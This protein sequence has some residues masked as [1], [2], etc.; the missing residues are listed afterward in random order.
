MI[1]DWVEG[2][3]LICDERRDPVSVSWAQVVLAEGIGSLMEIGTRYV[4]DCEGDVPLRAHLPYISDA[5]LKEG[6]LAPASL[7]D[8]ESSLV[9]AKQ[10]EE[11]VHELWGPQLDGKCGVES[12][13]VAAGGVAPEYPRREGS[14]IR[15]AS[16][17]GSA[18]GHA[19]IDV[20][21]Y[22]EPVILVKCHR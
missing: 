14:M 5:S 20:E 3:V 6:I 9:I 17:E 2:D 10:V 1:W 8:C 7:K 15:S 18:A 4:A 16:C 13:E 19:S 22:Q 11:L 21:L 12:L